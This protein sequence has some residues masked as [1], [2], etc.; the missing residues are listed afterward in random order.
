MNEMKKILEGIYNNLELRKTIAPLF[1]S[2][3]GMGKTKVIEEFAKEK[4]VELVEIITSQI[5]PYEVSG[6]AIPSHSKEMMTFYDFD[7]INNLKDGS[8]LFFDE[9]LAGQPVVLSACLT[10]IEQ[11]RT[12]SGKALPNIM[13]VG[14][15]NPQNQLPLPPAVKERFIWYNLKFDKASWKE[16]MSKY[17]ITD[18]IF[19]LLADLVSNE[20]F[21]NSNK[22]FYTPRS[23][24][25][26][27]KMI[28]EDIP[29][30]YS[31]K[32]KPILETKIINNQEN[33]VSLGDEIWKKGEGI[34][35]LKLQKL[36]KQLN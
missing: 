36:M 1:I 3:P 25:K 18:D 4:G 31:T 14:A 9:L 32:I 35:W 21:S 13:I 10:L 16:Y 34:S 23:V 22:N 30:P 33:D 19:E 29:T 8:I 26:A 5:L 24:E 6:M 27:I 15:A 7:K 17:L 2:N 11:R 28:L 20:T 12:I